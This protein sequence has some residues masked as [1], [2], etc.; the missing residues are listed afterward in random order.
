MRA[1]EA[2][3]APH[4]YLFLLFREPK[5]LELRKEDVGGD[6]FVQ[7]RS[8]DAAAFVQ[9]HALELVAVNWMHGVGDGWKAGAS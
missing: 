7:R 1:N 6:E 2:S 4:R 9:K 8:F 3:S 5:G